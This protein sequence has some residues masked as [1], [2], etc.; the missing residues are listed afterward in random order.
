MKKFK[1]YVVASI[2]LITLCF[3]VYLMFKAEEIQQYVMVYA[4]ASPK[5][6]GVSYG[7]YLERLYL[8]FLGIAVR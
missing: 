8:H 6:P 7:I 5:K 4:N 2:L 3:I 1:I